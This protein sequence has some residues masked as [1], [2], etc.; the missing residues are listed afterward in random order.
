MAEEEGGTA[1]GLRCARIL[2]NLRT[3]M[4]GSL[5]LPNGQQSLVACGWME[6]YFNL[7][8]DSPP[9]QGEEIHLEP[10]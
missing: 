5:H 7:V 3:T 1:V 2:K 6:Y 9:C 4:V 8:G 10:V